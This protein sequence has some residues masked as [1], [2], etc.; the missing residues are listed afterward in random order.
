MG[1]LGNS[2]NHYPKIMGTTKAMEA[3]VWIVTENTH[4]VTIVLLC[5]YYQNK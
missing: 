1:I 2:L 3:S 5:N 4:G